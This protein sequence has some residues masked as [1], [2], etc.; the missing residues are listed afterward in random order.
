MPPSSPERL[1]PSDLRQPPGFF[2]RELGKM[3]W[4]RLSAADA[5]QISRLH[6]PEVF[7]DGAP[8]KGE[9][10]PGL[11]VRHLPPR[12]DSELHQLCLNLQ[13]FLDGP[14]THHVTEA[15]HG[16]QEGQWKYMENL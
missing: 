13:V 2:P 3:V 10:Y 9:M 1:V 8:H 7:Y 12:G 11:V 6:R 16:E 15:P 4:Y 14:V 5:N